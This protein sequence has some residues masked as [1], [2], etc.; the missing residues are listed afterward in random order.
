MH[1]Q[2][3]RFIYVLLCFSFSFIVCFFLVRFL[4]KRKTR[5]QVERD[6]AMHSHQ[7]KDG[8][9]TMGGIAII[10]TIFISSLIFCFDIFCDLKALSLLFI[11]II[12]FSI[13]LVDDYLKIKMKNADKIKAGTVR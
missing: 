1:N 7:K 3:G 10:S 5:G 6:F 12:Y 11:A 8:T 4:I 9:P 13:G 2:L